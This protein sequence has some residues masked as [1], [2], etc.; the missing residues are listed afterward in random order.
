MILFKRM[1]V[2]T[3]AT[4]WHVP[5]HPEKCDVNYTVTA[6]DE[7]LPD[8]CFV[9]NHKTERVNLEPVY[10]EGHLQFMRVRCYCP[11]GCGFTDWV[12]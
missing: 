7:D 11:K 2:H 8:N 12:A 3:P 6:W 10:I 1:P 5:M 4:C 9:C